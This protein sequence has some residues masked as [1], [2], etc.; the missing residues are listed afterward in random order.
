M[1]S[2]DPTCKHFAVQNEPRV[3]QCAPPNSSCDI[4]N[5][6]RAQGRILIVEWCF[7]S[8]IVGAN[9]SIC[10]S[11]G[12]RTKTGEIDLQSERAIGGISVNTTTNEL[13]IA[14]VASTL[15]HTNIKINCTVISSNGENCGTE[16]FGLIVFRL[17]SKFIFNS[18]FLSTCAHWGQLCA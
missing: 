17:P 5:T 4:N 14:S 6:S 1:V 13:E 11:N 3:I 7:A 18:L 16:E 15:A 10:L 8:V 12:S 9:W 2:Q